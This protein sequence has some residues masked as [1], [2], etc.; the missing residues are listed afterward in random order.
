MGQHDAPR[1]EKLA[2]EETPPTL[3]V[4]SN[5]WDIVRSTH[6]GFV[7]SLT[8]YLAVQGRAQPEK[9]IPKSLKN[10]VGAFLGSRGSGTLGTSGTCSPHMFLLFLLLLRAKKIQNSKFKIQNTAITQTRAQVKKTKKNVKSD[11]NA[12]L[13]VGSAHAI[14]EPNIK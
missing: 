1:R 14:E 6:L 4:G 13:N 3:R 12:G 9:N 5:S 10:T 11:E 2:L 8:T 7:L